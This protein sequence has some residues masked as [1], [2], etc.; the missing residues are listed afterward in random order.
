MRIDIFTALHVFL[1]C[2]S[3]FG[4]DRLFQVG[5]DLDLHLVTFEGSKEEEVLLDAVFSRFC[6]GK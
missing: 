3:A 1:G 4:S 5:E 6:V 2:E